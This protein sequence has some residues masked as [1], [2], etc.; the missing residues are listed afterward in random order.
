MEVVQLL[1]TG[2]RV[3]PVKVDT[4]ALLE[5]SQQFAVHFK[6]VRGQ[7]SA[8]RAIE[9]AAAAAHNLLMIGSPGSGKTMLAKRMPTILPPLT[10]EAGLETTKIHSVAGVLDSSSGLVGTRAPCVRLLTRF[11]MRD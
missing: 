9:V 10:F 11:Q 4:P 3:Q 2:N 1:D 8:K 5:T 6:D 7:Q